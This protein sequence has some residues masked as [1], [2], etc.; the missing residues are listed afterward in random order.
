MGIFK[1]FTSSEYKEVQPVAHEEVRVDSSADAA[2]KLAAMDKS[3]AIIEFNLDG[4]VITANENFLSVLGYSLNEITGQHHSLFVDPAYKASAEYTQFWAKLNRGEFDAGEYKRVGK[5]GKEVWIQASYNP[6]FDADGKVSKVVKFA[7]DITEEKI[8]NADAM[9][10]LAAMD[11]SQAVIEFTLDGAVITAN[12]N[13]LSVLGYRLDEIVGQHH[14]LFVEPAYKASAEYTQFWAKLNRG[15]FD[16]GEYK[17][18]GK[19][20]KEVWIQASYNPIHDAEGKVS[21]VVKFA[22]DITEEKVRSADAAGKLAA[23]DKAQ[24]VIEFTLD[25]KVLTANENFLSVLGYSLAEVQNQHHSMFVEPVYKASAEYTQFWA[26]LNRGE[27][28]AGE[29]M[30]IGKGGKEIWIQASY[31]P[32]H[33]AEGRV[34]KVVKFATDVTEQKELQKMIELVLKDTSHVMKN[35]SEGNLKEKM[36]GVYTGDFLILSSSVNDCI[37]N[38][39]SMV[40]NITESAIS[41][42]EGAAEISSGNTN[43]SQRTEENAASLEETSAAMEEITTTVQQNAANAVQANTLARGARETA[44]NGGAVVGTAI[45]AMQAISESSNKIND[46]IGV[47]DEIAFQTNLLALNAAVEAARAGDQGRGFAVVADEVRSL[48][49][50]SATAAKEIKELI[51]DS[52]ERVK[53]GSDLVNK[54]GV[55][56]EEIVTAVKK[57]NDIVAEIS[58]ASDEQATGLDEINK[59]MGEMDEMT[60]QNAALVEEAAAAS[61]SLSS[62]AENLEELI[63]FFDIGTRA[64]ARQPNRSSAPAP[65]TP[66]SAQKASVKN[67]SQAKS[68]KQSPSEGK[69]WSEF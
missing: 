5:G 43:L 30:R 12:D 61:E 58:T 38:L 65:R 33:D 34:V 16:A 46:I 55:T 2:G 69:D 22:T 63:S 19:G 35:I 36:D 60:Q 23:I 66:A 26:K 29:Y 47:I 1:N 67:A 37:D 49:G 54:S 45:T 50:R 42:K 13:F 9:G 44:E 8:R 20:G 31:N 11:K 41:V 68:D 14:S 32:I 64:E 17:R 6:I 28:D 39:T 24:A 59:A 48:A 27:F 10:K 15:E 25:G 40:S 57:V 51:K 56:L 53:E 3:Q 4:T 7:T 21:K 52:S 62:Q 18:I